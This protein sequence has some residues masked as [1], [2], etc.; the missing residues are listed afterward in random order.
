MSIMYWQGLLSYLLFEGK[1]VYSCFIV[2]PDESQSRVHCPSAARKFRHWRISQVRHTTGR[3]F[4]KVHVQCCIAGCGIL[5]CR[6]FRINR[7]RKPPRI[8]CPRM[9]WTGT[10]HQVVSERAAKATASLPFMKRDDARGYHAYW[11]S[12]HKGGPMTLHT[13]R[14]GHPV[15][16][17]ACQCFLLVLPTISEYWSIDRMTS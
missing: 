9:H 5:A 6:Q 12:N 11:S 13:I 15:F 3:R 4:V 2:S 17:A 7:V 14:R 16:V 10:K 1:R 8:S